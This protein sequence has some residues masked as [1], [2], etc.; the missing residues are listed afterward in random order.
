M[1]IAIL[2]CHDRRAMTERALRG[3]LRSAAAADVNLRAVLYDD[4]SSDGTADAA[5]AI[6]PGEALEVLQGTG[7]AFWARSMAA[8][9][10]RALETAGD[11][12][13]LLWLNDDVS[14]HDD[15]L[16]DLLAVV[17]GRRDRIAVGATTDPDSDAMNY[18]GYVRSGPHPLRFRRVVPVEPARPVDT[19]NGNCVLVPV[20]AARRIGGIEGGYS[21]S[22]AD[23]DYG[24]RAN[25]AGVVP[26]L[27]PRPVGTCPSHPPS[28]RKPLLVEWAAF[29]SVKG[30]GHPASMRRILRRVRPRTW[31]L[32]FA[33]SCTA[34][35]LRALGGRI[36]G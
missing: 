18:G 32:F 14:L 8:A 35:W 16:L 22:L 25:A 19:F 30:G 6:L 27:N 15:A 1:I 9:E 13:L 33:W 26:L 3:L 10:R 31:P 29:R 5:R 2:A 21:H 36:G 24:L 11:D 34:W 12:D 23:I 17:D 20:P 4:G 7:D 28:S